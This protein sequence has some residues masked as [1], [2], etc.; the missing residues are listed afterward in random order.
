MTVAEL[1]AAL[2]RHDP[3]AVVVLHDE[4]ERGFLS[5]TELRPEHLMPCR[6]CYPHF[7]R[8]PKIS[9][10]NVPADRRLEALFIN[11][12]RATQHQLEREAW[13]PLITC[14]LC[15]GTGG[16]KGWTCV[17]CEGTGTQ[18]T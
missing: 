2:Q 9:T 3:A 11:S 18:S 8:A 17:A 6:I 13:A 1:I 16:G 4:H 14:V 10:A 12:E 7:D 15:R 5:I